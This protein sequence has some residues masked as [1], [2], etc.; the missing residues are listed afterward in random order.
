M[1]LESGGTTS[2]FVRRNLLYD[3]R[4][5]CFTFRRM[6]CSLCP[7]H[8]HGMAHAH[9]MPMWTRTGVGSVCLDSDTT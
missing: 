1:Y 5:M 7:S 8:G 3:G 4:K 9:A 6:L 2:V